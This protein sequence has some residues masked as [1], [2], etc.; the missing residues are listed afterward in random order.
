[1]VDTLLLDHNEPVGEESAI[2]VHSG[3][4]GFVSME[5]VISV[6]CIENFQ[7]SD[8]SQC[9]PGFTGTD[10]QQIDYCVVVNCSGNGQCVDGVDSFNCSCEPGFTGELCQTNIDECIRVNC[11]GNGECLD[12][13]NSYT[14][15]CSPGF[16]G[17]LCDIQGK[18]KC[19]L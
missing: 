15:E 18:T 9:V 7:G 16:T 12:G 6:T 11:S 19:T 3:M 2:Q 4:C 8:C 14:C 1:M 13:V 10:C 17:Q 5:L